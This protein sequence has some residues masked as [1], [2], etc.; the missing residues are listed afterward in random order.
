[1]PAK[2]SQVSIVDGQQ[3]K[4]C[5]VCGH[6]KSLTK[7]YRRVEVKDGKRADCEVCRKLEALKKTYKKYR[8]QNRHENRARYAVHDAVKSGKLIRAERCEDCGTKT[9]TQGHHD[10]YSK[11]LVVRWFRKEEKCRKKSFG[12]WEE[13]G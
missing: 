12:G 6:W 2:A 8:E 10:N 4:V 11:K 13:A 9:K 7:Y 5:S 1:M 3:G